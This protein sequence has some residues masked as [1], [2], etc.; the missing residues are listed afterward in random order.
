L[1]GS[2]LF[3]SK[4]TFGQIEKFIKQKIVLEGRMRLKWYWMNFDLN[5]IKRFGLSFPVNWVNGKNSVEHKNKL[6]WAR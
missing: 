1:K 6:K 2:K 4:S 5:F 3:D